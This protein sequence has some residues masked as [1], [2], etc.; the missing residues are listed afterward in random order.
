MAQTKTRTVA[1]KMVCVILYAIV[2]AVVSVWILSFFFGFWHSFEFVAAV[3]VAI[4]CMGELLLFINPP[5]TENKKSPEYKRHRLKELLCIS[6]VA[7]G[8][9]LEL[10]ALNHNMRESDMQS[11]E[12][13]SLT[14]ET[15]R[16]SLQLEETK[17]QLVG[18][19]IKLA[20]IKSAI[21]PRT[22]PEKQREIFIATLLDTNIMSPKIDIKVLV[23]DVDD[24]EAN[25]FAISVRA[26]LN[27]AGYGTNGEGVIR[28]KPF[29][30]SLNGG[31]Q[32]MPKIFAVFAT[33][34]DG[35]IIPLNMPSMGGCIMPF[36]PTKNAVE[37]EIGNPRIPIANFYS[38][39]P[40]D[41][42]GGVRNILN[43][44]GLSTAE[45]AANNLLKPNE[46]GFYIP[47][48]VE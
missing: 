5:P 13:A 26:M 23:Q 36:L 46:V 30:V 45:L 11:A 47:P 2:A 40:N 48:Q 41:I 17:L 44:I 21:P 38:T 29:S 6:L 1:A 9:T 31:N 16:V 3:C 8:V 20:A 18:A 33:D 28:I 4:G 42:L 19:N 22:I 37:A 15:V 35:K 7:I 10:V 43:Y 14:N 25:S 34:N 39:Y 32:R 12:I 24:P 27:D